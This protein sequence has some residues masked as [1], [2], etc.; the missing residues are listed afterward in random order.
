M[1][2]PI[3]VM[4][5]G[6]ASRRDCRRYGEVRRNRGETGE[7]EGEQEKQRGNR[8]RRGET[9]KKRRRGEE[10]EM[11]QQPHTFQYGEERRRCRKE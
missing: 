8:R 1:Y 3:L 7:T 2:K 6:T 9:E 4:T 11:T 10:T 5:P